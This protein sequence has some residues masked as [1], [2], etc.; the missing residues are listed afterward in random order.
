MWWTGERE[1]GAEQF[2]YY[3]GETGDLRMEKNSL[4]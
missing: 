2:E 3:A 4:L 1:R